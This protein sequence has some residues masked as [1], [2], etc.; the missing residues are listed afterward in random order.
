MVRIDKYDAVANATIGPCVC[1][2]ESKAVE[3]DAPGWL[4]RGRANTGGES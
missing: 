2:R 3:S 4:L 1:V